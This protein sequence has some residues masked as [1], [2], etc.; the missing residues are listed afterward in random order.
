MD[1]K[2]TTASHQKGMTLL[3]LLVVMSL[4]ALVTSLLIQGFGSALQT[5]ER[6]QR[7]H[8]QSV[9]LELGYKWFSTTLAGTQAELD[10]PRHFHGDS[11]SFTGTTHQPLLGEP[12]QVS[13]FSWRLRRANDQSLQLTYNQPNQVEWVIANWPP[14][15]QGRFIYRNLQGAPTQQW[16]DIN[17]PKMAD[18]RIPG[19]VLL[20]VTIDGLPPLRWYANMPGRTFPRPDYR[21]L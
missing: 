3:E 19:A 14:S 2:H 7:K 13:F 4:L 16:P 18:G 21:D 10:E 15:S 6:V 12:G 8:N 1:C 5:Y 9:P 17:D 20:E 11:Q